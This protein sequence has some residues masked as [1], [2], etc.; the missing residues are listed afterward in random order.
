MKAK[1]FALGFSY[2]MWEQVFDNLYTESD[3]QL[4]YATTLSSNMDQYKAHWPEAVIH[5][6]LKAIRGVPEQSID[7]MYDSTVDKCMLDK[8]AVAEH[9]ALSMMTRMDFGGRFLYHE[10]FRLYKKLLRY[11]HGVLNHFQPDFV[12]MPATPHAIYDYI[13]YVLCQDMQI[14]VLMFNPNTFNR[15][16]LLSNIE[17][18]LEGAVEEY[19]NTCDD[20]PKTWQLSEQLETHFEYVTKKTDANYLFTYTNYLNKSFKSGGGELRFFEIRY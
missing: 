20:M 16:Y 19:R 4:I 13:V 5:D 17:N 15:F 3:F 2:E 12:L 8:F 14:P 9:H 7:G 10:R 18:G 1:Y 11:W 6:L